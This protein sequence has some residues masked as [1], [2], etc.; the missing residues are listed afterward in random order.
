MGTGDTGNIKSTY[1][2]NKKHLVAC[3]FLWPTACQNF[4]IYEPVKK[5]A[6]FPK[7]STLYDLHSLKT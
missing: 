4:L 2:L 7:T 3:F 1:N 5:T 6:G